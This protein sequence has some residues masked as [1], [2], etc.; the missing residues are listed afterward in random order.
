MIGA[1]RGVQ[2]RSYQLLATNQFTTGGTQSYPIPAGTS[3]LSV[4]LWGG[5][6]GGAGGRSVGNRPT[7]YYGG[8]GGG[9]GGYARYT[10]YGG[11]PKTGFFEGCANNNFD[12]Q[13]GDL[14]VLYVGAGGIGG[15]QGVNGAAGTSTSIIKHTRN[16]I[17]VLDHDSLTSGDFDECLA[18]L[19]YSVV[20]GGGNGGLTATI[21]PNGGSGGI[22]ILLTYTPD[23]RELGSEE[24]F[25]GQGN[26]GTSTASGGGT[27][28]KAGGFT[29][30]AGGNGGTGGGNNG[31]PGIA[32][33]FPGGG[34]GGGGSHV[35]SRGSGGAGATGSI[36]IKAY[37]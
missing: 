13:A 5:G 21:V 18:S 34:G 37:G 10:M 27:G 23:R 9:G 28:G 32:G 1:A 4:E 33:G 35:T 24:G 29:S 3:Y 26:N 19:F 25:R 11:Q 2:G 31:D 8:G 17:T 7:N 6:G 14:L 22:G 12:M 20:A 30:Y 15:N 16:G 36:I